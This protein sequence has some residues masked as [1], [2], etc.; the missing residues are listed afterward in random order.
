MEFPG[1]MS[2]GQRAVLQQSWLRLY[3]EAEE[4]HYDPG[5]SITLV[6]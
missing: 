2:L 3:S 1:V 5:N 6:P 4:A